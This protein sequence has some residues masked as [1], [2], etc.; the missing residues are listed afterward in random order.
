MKTEFKIWIAIIL[1]VAVLG[2]IGIVQV[3]FNRDRVSKPAQQFGPDTGP[4]A[5]APTLDYEAMVGLD[6]Q[7][8]ATNEERVRTHNLE[9]R[10]QTLE[11][12]VQI[13]VA[14]VRGKGAAGQLGDF[15]PPE[16]ESDE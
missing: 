1:V 5:D 12:V 6:P 7:T 14:E 4:P 13:L 15:P 9:E 10:V 3:T 11:A 16:M 8:Q 2:M